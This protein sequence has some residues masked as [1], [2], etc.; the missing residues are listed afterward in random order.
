MN[1]S[2]LPTTAFLDPTGANRAEIEA[3]ARK[4]LD[5][6]L[7]SA[8]SAAD[9]S[10]VPSFE[11]FP[12]PV[13][14]PETSRA[15]DDLLAQMRTAL[16][17]SMN[18]ASP[19]YLG[20]MDP[21]ASTFSMLGDL[22]VASL[23]NNMLAV[24]MSPVFSRLEMRLLRAFAQRFGLGDNSGGVLLS[25]GSLGNLQ[26]LTVAR[27]R[28]FPEAAEH[29]LHRLPQPPV[30]LASE[31]AHTSLQKV[32]MLLGLGTQG[33]I[34]V[35]TNA[36]SQMDITDLRRK[37]AQAKQEGKAPFAIVGT[38]GT[39]VTG[40]IDPIPE[41]A[42][43]AREHHL[44]LHVDAVYGGALILS[45]HLRGMLEGVEQADSLTF[46]PQKWLY[47]TKVC[48]MTL[49]RDFAGMQQAFRIG[50][51]YMTYAEDVVNLG[52]ISVQGTRH[53]DVLKLW[54]SLQHIGRQAHASLLEN[55]LEL[56]RFFAQ[57]IRRRPHLRLLQDPVL[58]VV[59]FRAEP[60]GLPAEKWD[61]LNQHLQQA[62]LRRHQTFFSLPNYRS[63]FW[64]RSVLLNPWTSEQTLT[65]ALQHIDAL[66]DELIDELVA[67]AQ[68]RPAQRP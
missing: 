47:V 61:A 1:R 37:L 3:L 6:V 5:L 34:P 64:L 18:P 12:F 42:A 7:A 57:E 27:N 35:A 60:A 13:E 25:G 40:S 14:I 51:P 26:A 32:G 28:S 4:V 52:E 22:V 49:F 33:I 67:E 44:W 68:A 9:R 50:A 39:T 24:E 58:N 21:L 8:A 20:H 53:P 66:M 48:A 29:G 65:T 23:N 45:D 54:L 55:S 30:V 10:P 43:V 2:Q 56:A 62:L 38:V 46:N 11:E 17:G 63:N 15:L 59:V 31:A 41:I 19:N 36:H 16:A